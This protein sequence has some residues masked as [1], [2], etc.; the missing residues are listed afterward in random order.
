[1]SLKSRSLQFLAMNILKRIPV[2]LGSLF[3]LFS[4][5]SPFYLASGRFM[6]SGWAIYYW[7]YKSETHS[8]WLGIPGRF[9]QSWFSDYWFSPFNFLPT[10]VLLSMFVIQVLILAFSTISIFVNRRILSLTPV[11]L[12]MILLILMIHAGRI[13][14]PEYD[15]YQTGYYLVYPSVFLFAAAF[16]L[17]DS[18]STRNRQTP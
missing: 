16:T 1:L 13:M 4:L 17:S 14:S 6:E 2:T 8:Y 9:S 10:W 18:P 5:I 7:S 15:G 3:F 12:S 11:Y